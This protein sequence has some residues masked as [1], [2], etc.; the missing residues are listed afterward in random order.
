MFNHP[1]TRQEKTLVSLMRW[2]IFIFAV[3]GLVFAIFPNEVIFYL[4]S[5]GR[6]VFQWKAMPLPPSSERFWLVLAVVM[7]VMLVFSAFKAQQDIVKNISYVK[8]I[9]LAKFSSTVGFM[10]AFLL[11]NQS[12]AYLAGA[13]IDGLLCIIIFFAFRR[14]VA[15]RFVK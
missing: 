12:F 8:L 4:N 2:S 14:A 15:S 13:A 11:L 3:A 10:T 5:I 1:V 9:I 7:M 6:T